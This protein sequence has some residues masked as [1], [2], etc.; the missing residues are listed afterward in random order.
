MFSDKYYHNTLMEMTAR[1]KDVFTKHYLQST[2]YKAY[3]AQLIMTPILQNVFK[4]NSERRRFHGS[5]W[6]V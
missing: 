1:V 6:G 4:F 3:K 2:A 5:V